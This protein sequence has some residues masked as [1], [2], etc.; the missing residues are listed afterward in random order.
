MEIGIDSPSAPLIFPTS[1]DQQA[2]LIGGGAVDAGQMAV[3][4]GTS[5]VV[6]SSSMELPATDQLDVM[7]LNW[8]PYLWMRCYNNGAQFLNHIVG[9]HPD[10]QQLEADARDVGAGCK[11]IMVSPFMFPEPSLGVKKANLRWEPKKPT[12]EGVRF[13]AALEALAYMIA[14][15]VRQH[16]DS[17]QN[18][19][20]ITVSGGIARSQ[21]M[22][23]ILASV[24]NRPLE[25]LVSN[26]GPALGAA[27]TALAAL[28]NHLRRG[29]ADATPYTVVDAV[30][31]MVKFRG[32]VQPNEK[33]RAAYDKGL[34]S[35]AKKMVG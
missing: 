30:A 18:I 32:S 10:W 6:N 33:W 16:E 3:I 21:L 31:R 20:R 7:R 1:D 29:Q 5:A 9:K 15:G 13:R 11:G 8:G 2:G 24:L 22:C 26:E 12:K 17:G 23:E 25:L 14:L 4:L 28:E 35:F 19:T 27:V 34:R